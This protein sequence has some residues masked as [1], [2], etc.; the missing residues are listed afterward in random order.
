MPV[1]GSSA[2]EANAIIA[3]AKMDRVAGHDTGGGT[4]VRRYDPSGHFVC[5]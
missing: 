5:R 1:A 4:A 2:S 3:M